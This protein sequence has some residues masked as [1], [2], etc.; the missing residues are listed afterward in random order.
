[1]LYLASDDAN[2]FLIRE[3]VESEF[4]EF[5]ADPGALDSAER[6]VGGAPDG[7]V[8]SHHADFEAVGDVR[9]LLLVFGAGETNPTLQSNCA[10]PAVRSTSEFADTGYRDIPVA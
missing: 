10:F 9:S 1:M 8:D 2:E 5:A 6:Q 3:L 4:A 7:G